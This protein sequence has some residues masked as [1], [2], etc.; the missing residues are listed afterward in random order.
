MPCFSPPSQPSP[1]RGKEENASL[2]ERGDSANVPHPLRLFRDDGFAV[3]SPPRPLE[4]CI[5]K[6]HDRPLVA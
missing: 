5:R 4:N 2:D 6:D 1:T 3:A